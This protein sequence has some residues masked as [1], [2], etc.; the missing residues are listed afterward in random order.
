MRAHEVVGGKNTAR[1]EQ[2]SEEDEVEG[3][4]RR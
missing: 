4:E 1:H 3:E 2:G